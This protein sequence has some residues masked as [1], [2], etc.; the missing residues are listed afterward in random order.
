MK[1]HCYFR[2]GLAH[3]RFWVGAF[4]DG[5]KRHGWEVEV[6]RDEIKPSDLLVVWGVRHPSAFAVQRA[7]AGEICV[8]ER[9]YVGNRE[10]WTSVSFGGR[11]NGRGEFRG[12]LDDPWRW[13]SYF[14][15]RLK[16]WQHRSGYAL[17]MGQVPNDQALAGVNI[18]R[19]YATMVKALRREGHDV[20]FR[21]H[22]LA[23]KV[24]VPGCTTLKGN[25]ADALERAGFVVT[26][27]SNSAVDAVLD[28]VPAVAMDAGSMA[29][30]VAG[31]EP[32][33]PPT[34]DRG[35]WAAALAWKQWSESEIRSGECWEYVNGRKQARPTDNAGAGDGDEQRLERA[36]QDVGH[37]GR[38][39]GHG[40]SDLQERG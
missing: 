21:P 23:A 18:G 35:R 11:L 15:E 3:H 34:P 17:I 29:W 22:P 2:P 6:S 26:W 27:N 8:L 28:G 1:A 30:D 10:L 38:A 13:E 25:L 37:A 33:R 16:D 4:A 12:A 5:L 39:A 32:R 7:A 31:H 24:R 14:P 36:D 9:G 40:Q 19:W 20:R